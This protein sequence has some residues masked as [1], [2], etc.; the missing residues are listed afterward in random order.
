MASSKA[1]GEKEP[2]AYPLG[3]V[4]DSAE[5]RTKLEAI[6]TILLAEEGHYGKTHQQIIDRMGKNP[7]Q[8]ASGLLVDPSP[9]HAAPT[10][11]QQ[12]YQSIAMGNAEDACADQRSRQK[13]ELPAEDREQQSTKREFFEQGRKDHVFD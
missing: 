9:E 11:A 2:E 7:W 6:F 1:R 3:Y 12:S 10:H 13:T 8:E 5:P 4:E